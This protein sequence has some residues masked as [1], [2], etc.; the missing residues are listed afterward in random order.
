[1]LATFALRI[2]LIVLIVTA[3]AIPVAGVMGKL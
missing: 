3:A 1:M 2:W